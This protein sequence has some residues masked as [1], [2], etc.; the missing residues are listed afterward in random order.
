[1]SESANAE[2]LSPSVEP[3]T[4][5]RERTVRSSG[6]RGKNN[7]YPMFFASLLSICNLRK[8]KL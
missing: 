3:D 4:G 2:G 8:E 5:S 1:M 6:C 7:I